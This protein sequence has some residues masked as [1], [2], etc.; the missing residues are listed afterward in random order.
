MGREFVGKQR[1]VLAADARGGRKERKQS[2]DNERTVSARRIIIFLNERLGK[3]KARWWLFWFGF[4]RD[5][6]GVLYWGAES[7]S[8]GFSIYI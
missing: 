4:F 6:R 1:T 5:G 8:M 2:K 3:I 7:R